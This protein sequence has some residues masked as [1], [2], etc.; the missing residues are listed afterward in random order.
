MYIFINEMLIEYRLYVTC[1]AIGTK[2]QRNSL[3]E[4]RM[5]QPSLTQKTGA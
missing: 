2:S 1:E 3:E 5:A 4:I